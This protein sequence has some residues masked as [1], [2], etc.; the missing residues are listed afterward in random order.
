MPLFVDPGAIVPASQLTRPGQFDQTGDINAAAVI[1]YGQSVQHT[2]QRRSVLAPYVNMR[3]VRGTNRVGNYGFGKSDVGKVVPGE[4]PAASKNDIGK[5]TLIIDTLVY[6]RH[7]LPLLETFQTSYDARVELGVEDG[8][9]MA[10]FTDQ[11]FMIQAA[12]AALDT[13]SRYSPDTTKPAGFAGG[14][15]EV[16]SSAGDIDDP[17]RFYKAISNLFATMETKDVVPGQD[18]VMLAMKPKQFYALL[19]AEQIINGNYVT[20]RGTVIENAMIFK[21]FGCPVIRSN[22]FP[23]GTVS[24]HLLSTTNNG[25][26]YDGD[27]SKLAA[28]AF[29]PK[30]L[31]AGETIPLTHD[32]YYDKIFKSWIVDSHAAFGVT[33]DRSEYAGAI[34]LP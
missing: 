3:P 5:N 28:L 32:L 14:S 8:E 12:K 11:A 33:G 2:I 17:A 1:E 25:N 21:A 9:A 27:F 18:D 30:A 29:S 6:T 34:L 16:L 19:D 10:R 13:A 20:A 22:N 15:R 4:A 31:L 24:G 7:F 26:A 23:T